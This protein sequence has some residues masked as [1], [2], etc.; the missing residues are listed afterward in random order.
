MLAS[1]SLHHFLTGDKLKLIDEI[2]RLLVPGGA[3]VWIDAVRDEGEGRD[4]Y[5]DRLTHAM[6]ND[7]LGLTPDQRERGVAHVRTSDFPETA[8]WMFEHVEAA[9]FRPGATFLEDEF[10]GGWAFSM[11]KN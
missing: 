5:I 10:F 8:S 6:S 1:Y 2:R 7:W 4:Q 11:P 3:F 9:G